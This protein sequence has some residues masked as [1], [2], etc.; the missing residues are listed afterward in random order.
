MSAGVTTFVD[1]LQTQSSGFGGREGSSPPRAVAWCSSWLVQLI[2][3]RR[4]HPNSKRMRRCVIPLASLA[5]RANT[6]CLHQCGIKRWCWIGVSR[7]M[8]T[9][10]SHILPFVGPYLLSRC[11]SRL[12]R[13][14]NEGMEYAPV[15]CAEFF[16]ICTVTVHGNYPYNAT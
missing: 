8:S 10:G 16:N 5:D 1:S 12:A 3:M 13:I 11:T 15:F 7:S 2:A 9:R 14:D 6:D 4:S